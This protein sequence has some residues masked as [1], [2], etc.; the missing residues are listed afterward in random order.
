MARCVKTALLSIVNE[1]EM[2]L[3]CMDNGQIL[4]PGDVYN[5]RSMKIKV[6]TSHILNTLLEL[7]TNRENPIP[8]QL[9]IFLQ[10]YLL[11][12]HPHFR[13]DENEGL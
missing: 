6:R 2:N 1:P 9:A 11:P 3:S 13:T 4:L 7:V 10:N 8:E 12:D 5:S